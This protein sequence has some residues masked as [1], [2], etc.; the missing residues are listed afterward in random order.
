M[1]M[2][3]LEVSVEVDGEAA[4]AV[5]EVFNRF[6]RGGAVV[7]VTYS[8]D[9][10]YH[11]VAQPLVG[12]KTYL[13]VENEEAKQKLEEAIWYLGR[14]YP[15]PEPSFRTLAEEDWANVWKRSYRPLRI[16]DR[17]VVVPSWCEFVPAPGDVTVEL[18]PGMAFGTGLHP[19]TRMSLIAV[20]KYARAGQS[21][22]D[23]G[24]GSGILSIAA[25]RLGVAS[26]LAVEKD[27]LAAKVARENV[28]LNGVQETVSVEIGSL[29]KVSGMFDLLLVNILAEVIVSLVEGGLLSHLKSGGYFVAAGIVEEFET[30]VSQALESRQVEIVERFQ[31]KD[32]LTLVGTVLPAS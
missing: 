31:E 6:G 9:S 8:T 5:S 22:L 4:E 27:P 14:L 29:E 21:V 7:E 11:N 20:E 24:T 15:I 23:M 30:I 2:S 25:A 3:W 19:T 28:A 10:T 18:D 16:G 32:W 13:P 26:V 12:V 17:L 1:D